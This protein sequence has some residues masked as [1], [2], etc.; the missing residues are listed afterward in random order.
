MPK[1][2]PAKSLS[3]SPLKIF[4]DAVPRHLL[5]ET[6]PQTGEEVLQDIRT[7]FQIGPL[8]ENDAFFAELQAL[9][10]NQAFRQYLL[11]ELFFISEDVMNVDPRFDA[12]ARSVILAELSERARTL[13][14]L[15]DIQYIAERAANAKRNRNPG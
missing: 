12:H 7:E 11:R 4:L 5:T 6:D 1:P 3:S 14:K 10:G 13:R 9:G 8:P 15:I 2:K